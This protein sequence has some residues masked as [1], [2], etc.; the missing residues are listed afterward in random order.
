M[1]I[2]YAIVIIMI[3]LVVITYFIFRIASN[4]QQL[5]RQMNSIYTDLY[6]EA[7][8]S[9]EQDKPSSSSQDT[10]DHHHTVTFR[11]SVKKQAVGNTV[12]VPDSIHSSSRRTRIPEG[13]IVRISS[14]KEVAL[15]EVTHLT[16][17]ERRED[18]TN[19]YRYRVRVL[20]QEEYD[21]IIKVTSDYHA[22]NDRKLPSLKNEKDEDITTTRYN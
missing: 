20:K 16:D 11:E 9:E 10:E 5:S 7:T 8:R 19:L 18:R 3:A 22:F 14:G 6:P 17:I 4:M 2:L 12:L 13:G 1:D 21:K 15:A